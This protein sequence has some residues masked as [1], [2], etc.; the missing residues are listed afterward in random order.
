MLILIVQYCVYCEVFVNYLLMGVLKLSLLL[1]FFSFISIF[2][3]VNESAEKI[4]ETIND[5]IESDNIVD[6][7][8]KKD[9]DENIF[10]KA[11]SGD[12]IS[13]IVNDILNN[14][15]FK[16]IDIRTYFGLGLRIPLWLKKGILELSSPFSKIECV[17]L[18]TFNY[19]AKFISDA[20]YLKS[21]SQINEFCFSDNYGIFPQFDGV[22]KNY[23]GAENLKNIY[24]EL[25]SF[26]KPETDV[27]EDA[28]KINIDVSYLEFLS[29]MHVLDSKQL[30]TI[31]K[32]LPHIK[33]LRNVIKNSVRDF[34]SD[35]RISLIKNKNLLLSPMAFINIA[36]FLFI[37]NASDSFINN[38]TEMCLNNYF[39]AT[40]DTFNVLHDKLLKLLPEYFSLKFADLNTF[41]TKQNLFKDNDEYEKFCDFL[42]SMKNVLVDL[43]LLK[44]IDDNHLSNKTLDDVFELV[45]NSNDTENLLKFA[46]SVSGINCLIKDNKET[47]YNNI[48]VPNRDEL[49]TNLTTHKLLPSVKPTS[50]NELKE[51]LLTLYYKLLKLKQ[52]KEH[53]KILKS[54]KKEEIEFTAPFNYRAGVNLTYYFNK[55]IGINFDV[56]VSYSK[57]CLNKSIF[58][59]QDFLQSYFYYLY[60]LYVPS[61]YGNIYKDDKLTVEDVLYHK[62][63]LP[64]GKIVVDGLIKNIANRTPLIGSSDFN[65]TYAFDNYLDVINYHSNVDYSLCDLSVKLEQ[66]N[67]CLK[68]GIVFNING[69]INRNKNYSGNIMNEISVNFG[70]YFNFQRIKI[71]GSLNPK[72]NSYSP[73]D[74][75]TKCYT[76]KI[77]SD[78]L[79][80]V[81]MNLGIYDVDYGTFDHKIAQMLLFVNGGLYNSRVIPKNTK[82]L[83]YINNIFNDDLSEKCMT[84]VFNIFKVRYLL[85]FMYRFTIF[86]Y[87]VSV[88]C[89]LIFN[90]PLRLKS[91]K[92]KYFG[93]LNNGGKPIKEI[94]LSSNIEILP[95]IEFSKCFSF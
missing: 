75:N 37:K 72:Y 10:E 22:V 19:K 18:E 36:R 53:S 60:K 93:H 25:I 24:K 80:D 45:K 77:F 15:K 21:A 17:N 38:Y 43:K 79:V 29:G 13:Q 85:D 51:N 74:I 82:I 35:H 12:D 26:Y 62:V 95:Y 2:C 44:N 65:G 90:N 73:E 87:S 41:S 54:L 76:H 59:P 3:N 86:G 34:I 4:N 94:K 31:D 11:I 55:Y 64:V 57:L 23:A 48:D 68:S 84:T 92:N 8:S 89:E 47:I 20:L 5:V 42:K 30:E 70:F 6:E 50:H 33:K 27:S 7:V 49:I 39:K 69:F 83:G 56:S 9:L 40:G 67:I 58:L 16:N 14:K 46:K 28:K 78:A 88:G 81:L 91:N 66:I 61:L 71:T 32:K 1:Y 52:S 63:K